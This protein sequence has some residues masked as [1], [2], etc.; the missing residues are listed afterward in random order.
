MIEIAVFGKISVGKSALLNAI[1]A[2]T[3]FTVDPGA[4][5]TRRVQRE[6]VSFAG[7]GLTIIDT[8]GICEVGAP[9]RTREAKKAAEEAD[10]V[11]V[12]C[13]GDITDFEYAEIQ[14]LSSL[15]KPMLVILNKS[16]ILTQAQRSKL[17][18]HIDS[19]LASCVD[20]QNILL[21]AADP[22]RFYLVEQ[23]DGNIQ[24]VTRRTAPEVQNIQNRLAEILKKDGPTLELLDNTAKANNVLKKRK[25]EQQLE[26]KELIDNYALAIAVGVAVNP[27]PLLDLF[28]GGAITA[29]IAKLAKIYDIDLDT[30]EIS[31]LASNFVKDG[32]KELWI[33]AASIA[34]GALL[35]GIPLIGWA[36]G[37]MGVATGAFYITYIIG[38]AC[39]QY[40]AD[41]EQWLESS[42]RVTLQKIIESTDKKSICRRAAQEIKKRLEMR[43]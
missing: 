4:G 40:F 3:A 8:P 35:K 14:E 31:G 24:E 10:L 9:E 30:E 32:W 23:T 25:S 18:A 17:V 28:V 39:N 1:F 34:G 2:T 36:I 12:V 29:L 19:R 27:I 11:L 33:P 43:G 26:A 20:E 38:M 37:A 13:D 6:S 42:L 21:C 41:D 22:V 15:G 7:H 5:S 16:D